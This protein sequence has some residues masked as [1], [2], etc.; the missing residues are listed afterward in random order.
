MADQAGRKPTRSF[1]EVYRWW[2]A[3]QGAQPYSEDS[4][5]FQPGRG[6]SLHGCLRDLDGVLP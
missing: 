3:V 1:Y 4:P 6:R 5:Y 2:C